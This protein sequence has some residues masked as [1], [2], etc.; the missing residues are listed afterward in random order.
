MRSD[1]IA[2]W[3][4]FWAAW[5]RA[6]AAGFRSAAFFEDGKTNQHDFAIGRH[7]EPTELDGG[8]RTRSF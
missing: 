5:H 8:D 7:H 6:L 2:R 3:H 4:A 1:L